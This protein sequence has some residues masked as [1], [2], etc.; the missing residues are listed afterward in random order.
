MSTE[1]SNTFLENVVAVVFITILTGS[2][3]ESFLA[4]YTGA[5]MMGNNTLPHLEA[6]SGSS[7]NT[8]LHG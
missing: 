2:I 3:K 8:P 1:G 7:L 4:P 6:T 5:V